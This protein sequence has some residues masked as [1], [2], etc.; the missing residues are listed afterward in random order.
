MER[1]RWVLP[2]IGI[3]IASAL[4]FLFER[5]AA[6]L[7]ALSDHGIQ[8]SAQI[9]QTTS[10]ITAY[11]YTVDGAPYS[12]S[13][14][15]EKAPFAAQEIIRILVLP[16]DASF[17]RPTTDRQSIAKEAAGVRAFGFKTLAG[18]LFFF[19]GFAV[20]SHLQL[21]RAREGGEAALVGP[22]AV[23]WRLMTFGIVL[24]PFLIGITGWHFVDAAQR[25]G[26]IVAPLIGT[27]LIVAILGGQVW[28]LTRASDV[29]IGDRFKRQQKWL[30]PLLIVVGLARLA[31]ALFQN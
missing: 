19:L 17:S 15:R 14:E 29:P 8:A 1:A 9:T 27:V 28:W 23:R 12:W 24:A 7:T 30:V 21:M 26:S 3:A 5:S 2:L 10:S 18:I 20:I 6:R 13:V 16:E 25:D 31:A 22:E 11:A 4:G